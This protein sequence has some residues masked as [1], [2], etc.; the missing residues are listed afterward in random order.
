[1]HQQGRANRRR[2]LYGFTVLYVSYVF[3]R[4]DEYG[5][6]SSVT[7]EHSSVAARARGADNN[8]DNKVEQKSSSIDFFGFI[9]RMCRL[10]I[11]NNGP[12]TRSS[13]PQQQQQARAASKSSSM[14]YEQQQT[15]QPVTVSP[16]QHQQQRSRS[17][18]YCLRW[19]HSTHSS[20]ASSLPKKYLVVNPHL[21]NNN[22]NNISSSSNSNSNS[23]KVVHHL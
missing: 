1:M 17:S 7:P 21:H 23:N 11:R 14:Q 4:N 18:S 19:T 16:P 8:R 20:P 2:L 6:R 15:R 22:N 5:S 13:P 10:H 12:P 3:I 9:C